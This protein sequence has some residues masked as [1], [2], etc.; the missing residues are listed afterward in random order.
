MTNDPISKKP[1]ANNNGNPRSRQ[2]RRKLINNVLGR[3]EVGRKWRDSGRIFQN[4]NA[5]AS[6]K[7]PIAARAIRQL[8]KSVKTP[9]IKRPLMPPIELPLIYNPIEKATKL[10][11]ISSLR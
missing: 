7:Q 9:L 3:S 6:A 1:S 5:E 8:K 4:I 10:G 2:C 11:W